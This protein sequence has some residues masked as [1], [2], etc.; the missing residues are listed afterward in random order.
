GSNVQAHKH[1]AV[2]LLRF[3][4]SLKRLCCLSTLLRQDLSLA[5]IQA[6]WPSRFLFFRW[7]FLHHLPILPASR[8]RV[9]PAIKD[10]RQQT[11]E[12]KIY[13]QVQRLPTA[14]QAYPQQ[15][16]PCLPIAWHR[17][18]IGCPARK[19]CRPPGSFVCQKPEQLWPVRPRL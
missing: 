14:L 11:Q 3:Y 19:F 9:P 18:H 10:Q 7:C 16:L 4:S 1:S 5:I 17:L 2:L 15:L 12:R 8:H 6:V 13:L